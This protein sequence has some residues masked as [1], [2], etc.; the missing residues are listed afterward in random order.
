M[1]RIKRFASFGLVYVLLLWIIGVQGFI[2]S[3]LRV[4]PSDVKA[5]LLQLNSQQS[6]RVNILEQRLI[7]LEQQLKK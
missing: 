2:I 6:E 3:R 7:F 1:E 5:T 4:A